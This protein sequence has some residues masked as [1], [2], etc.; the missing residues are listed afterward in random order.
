[1]KPKHATSRQPSGIE[2]E[3]PD[4]VGSPDQQA[5]SLGQLW[6]LLIGLFLDGLA[7]PVLS[8]VFSMPIEIFWDL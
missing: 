8:F 6:W 2:I 5:E 3:S 1:V 7:L 4:P